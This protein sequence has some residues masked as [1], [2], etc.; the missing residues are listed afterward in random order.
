VLIFVVLIGVVGA[1]AVPASAGEHPQIDLERGWRQLFN[2]KDLTG[3]ETRDRDGGE[4]PADTWAVEDGTLARKGHAYLWT[5]DPFGDFVLDLEFKVSPRT[6]SGIILRHEAEP[7]LKTYWWNGLLEVQILDCYG[8]EV[9]NKHDCGALYDMIAPSKNVMR[10]AGEWNRITITARGSRVTVVMN[11]EQIVDCDLDDWD[12]AE[13]NPDGTPNKY[14]K[15]MK[16]LRRNGHVL[17][18]DHPGSIWFRNIF[19]KPLD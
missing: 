12:E 19:I 17:L 18:Q 16:E 3:W 15:P 13:K 8:K 7:G 10:K 1:S 14:H 5:K 2:G 9:P 11:G 6:N 4:V